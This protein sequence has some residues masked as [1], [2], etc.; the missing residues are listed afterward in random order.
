[1][2][3]PAV[4]RRFDLTDAEWTVLAP[5]L[6]AGRRPGRPSASTKRQLIDGI[7]WRLRVGAPWRDVPTCYGSWQAVYALFRRWQRAGIWQ[8]IVTGLQARADA[9][10]LI[11]WD[12]SVDSTVGRAHQHG[13]GA[14]VRRR[15]GRTAGRSGCRASRP[16]LGPVAGR[17]D[18]QAARHRPAQTLPRPG[19]PLRQTRRPLRSHHP[20]HRGERVA[21]RTSRHA[22]GRTPPVGARP[23][24][25]RV[26]DRLA[27]A[28]SQR[29]RRTGRL[30]A[31]RPCADTNR[32]GPVWAPPV[33]VVCDQ[34]TMRS[35]FG[36]AADG[37]LNSMVFEPALSCTVTFAEATS[38]LASR[39]RRR[40]GWCR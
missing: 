2:A 20:H 18:H 3:T 32:G 31:W 35:R 30:A 4:T 21:T 7:R 24:P 38:W 17:L 13:A 23:C 40:S 9:A 1:M 34:A 11:C 39:R 8:Q 19:H 12:V 37:L 27:G 5:L 28:A 25:R 6:P 26:P 22:L 33:R 36:A 16:C 10:G 14:R 15:T 29:I